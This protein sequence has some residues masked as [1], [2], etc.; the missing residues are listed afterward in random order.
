MNIATFMFYFFVITA[1]LTAILLLFTKNVLHGAFL[2]IITLLSLAGIYV[3]A[4]AEFIAVAQILI[5]AGGI[6]V[7]IIFAIMLTSKVSGKPLQ[8]EHG[9][10]INGMIVGG[11]FFLVLVFLISREEGLKVI[12][13]SRLATINELGIALMTEYSLPFEVAGIVLL[14]SLIGASVFAST[15]PTRP[16]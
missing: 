12:P 5:Y 11:S 10:V 16:D 13:Q 4:L 3:L 2:L 14:V 15:T 7:V 1:A 8:L 9:N 6:L